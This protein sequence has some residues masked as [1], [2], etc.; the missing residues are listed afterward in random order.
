MK[1]WLLKSEPDVFSLTDLENCE[2]RKDY[3]SGVRNYQ[4]RNF[5]RDDMKPGD[6]VLFY[7]SN[8]NPP[9]VVGLANIV[10]ESYPDPT[11]FD[12]QS[13][14]FDEK[15]T[16]DQPRWYVVDVEFAEHFVTPVTLPMIKE[17]AV[18]ADMLVAR[19]GQRLSVQPVEAAHFKRVVQLGTNIP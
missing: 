15:S 19:K 14:Y 12:P 2:G 6:R 16:R 8:C 4:A 17:D 9:A 13:E 11:Q 3:W 1:Y 10:S 5:I 7:H 18:L